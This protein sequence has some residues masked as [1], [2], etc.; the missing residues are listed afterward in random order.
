[1]VV[2]VMKAVMGLEM[3]RA[4][5]TVELLVHQGVF[6]PRDACQGRGLDLLNLIVG[7]SVFGRHL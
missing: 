2:V 3:W 6:L 1:M 7:V 4:G 5:L